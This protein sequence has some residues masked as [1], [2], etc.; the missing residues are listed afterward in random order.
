MDNREFRK[1]AHQLVD[2]MADYLENIERYPVK[3]QVKPREIYDQLPEQAPYE[4]EAM[5]ALM[6]DVEEIIMPGMTHWQNP[7]FY[8][9]FQGNSSYPSI[10]AE[11]LTATLAAQCMIWDTSPSAAELEEKMMN[12]LLEMCGLPAEWEGTIHSTAS[13]ATLAAILSAREQWSDF[14]VNESGFRSEDRM[15]VYCSSQTHSSIEKGAK[16]AGIGRENVVKIEVDDQLAMKPE[17]LEKAIADD[18]A[19][20]YHPICVIATLGTTSTHAMDPVRPIGEICR[21]HNLWFHIDAAHAGTALLLPEQ[22]GI[23]DGA[24][25]ADSFVFNPHKWMFINFDCSAYFVRDKGALIR[26]FE[27][28]P[29]YLKTAHTSQTNNYRD[30]GIPLGRRFRALKIWFVIRSFGLK[31]LQEKIREHIQISQN[32]ATE[33]DR[34]PDFE[35]C[36]QPPLNLVCF[37]YVPDPQISQDQINSLNAALLE[38][39]NSTGKLFITHTK[40]N[41]DYI[42]RMSIGQTY[43]EAE[44]VHSAW[45]LIQTTAKQIH[46]Q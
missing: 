44:H 35:L 15:R 25:M 4:P 7:N 27:I 11:M 12:W 33:I 32:L 10:L 45:E 20:G 24:E 36:Y 19:N 28:L 31:G 38:K 23:A 40:I 1:N 41:G 17:A 30:W 29:E 21:K 3:S 22:R 37:R 6:K 39:L 43:L 18:M 46:T 34:H 8:A 16:I 2:W 14:R 5:D 26:T 13:D 42:I 9:Y